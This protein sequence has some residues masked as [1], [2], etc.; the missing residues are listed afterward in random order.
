MPY[1][2]YPNLKSSTHITDFLSGRDLVT[3][4]DPAIVGGLDAVTA[5]AR[6]A[7]LSRGIKLRSRLISRFPH[8]IMRGKTDVTDTPDFVEFCKRLKALMFQVEASLCL[9][10][11]AYWLLDTN[12]NGYNLTPRWVLSESMTPRIDSEKGLIDFKRKNQLIPLERVVYFWEPSFTAEV[13]P[14]VGAG[15]TALSAASQLY[16]MDAFIS[17]YFNQGAVKVTVFPVPPGTPEAEVERFQSFLKRRLTGVRNAFQN[18]VMRLNDKLAPVIIGS[19]VKDTQAAELIVIQRDNVAAALE[20]PP[21]VM[22]G[23]SANFATAQS[24]YFGFVTGTI[25][26]RV[27]WLYEIVNEQYLSRLDAELV[28]QPEK[29]EIM[30]T[31]QLEQAKTL[32]ALTDEAIL[33]VDEA[34]A[35]MELGPK[36]KAPAPPQLV[37]P[38]TELPA[39]VGGPEFPALPS[40]AVPETLSAWRSTHLDAIKRG[41]FYSAQPYRDAL[42]VAIYETIAGELQTATGASAARTVFERH[43]PGAREDKSDSAVHVLE[44]IRLGV[45]ALSR[46]E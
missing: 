42:P 31:A 10:G 21:S 27:E 13:G 20:M 28:A 32:Y 24:D 35:Y 8:A 44:A 7:W 12:A 4:S 5:Y 36:P 29:L 22:D 2:A 43:W 41:V 37:A 15:Q 33:T 23:T 34:R 11:A 18:I 19:D 16:A 9:T 38:A 39:R 1:I 30:Q 46:E 14:G 17:Q 3:S 45:E 26:P 25:V 6:V 40:K